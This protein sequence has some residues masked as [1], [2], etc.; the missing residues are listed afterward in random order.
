MRNGSKHQDSGAFSVRNSQQTGDR[1]AAWLRTASRTPSLVPENVNRRDANRIT[2]TPAYSSVAVVPQGGGEPLAGHI[3]DISEKGLRFEVDRALPVGTSIDLELLV[4]PEES[5][6]VT[7]RIV[8]VYDE[9]D[10]PGPRRMGAE[11]TGFSSPGDEARLDE[12]LDFGFLIR[13]A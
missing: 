1:Q 12:L 5:I 2:V 3:Y 4:P 8:R 6:R 13:A 10:D 9:A 7:A 11:F